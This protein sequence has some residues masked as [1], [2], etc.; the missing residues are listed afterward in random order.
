[1]AQPSTFDLSEYI[2][3]HAQNSREW[4]VPFLPPVHLP[5]FLTLHAVMLLIGTSLLILIFCGLYRKEQ[6]V[7]SGFTNLLEAFVLFIRDKIAIANLGEEDGRK[8]TPFF[9]TLFFFILILNLMGLIPVFSTATANINVTTALTLIIFSL[10]TFGAILKNGMKGFASTFF[11][12][13]LPLP[14]QILLLPLEILGLFTRSFALALRLFA[15]MLAGHMVI[16]AFLGTGLAGW[17][18]AVPSVA[19]AFFMT[20]LEVLVVFLQAYIFTLLSAIF[21]GQMYHPKH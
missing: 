4:P 7:P 20:L 13:N 3:H 14:L 1:M 5:S 16:L 8:F 17:L 11:L 12:P 21:I 6:K 9:C 2:M 15:N 19:M 18:V 10:M